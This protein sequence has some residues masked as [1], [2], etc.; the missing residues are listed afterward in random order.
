MTLPS[1]GSSSRISRYYDPP[2]T[3]GKELIGILADGNI[4]NL[5][6][7]FRFWIIWL[8]RLIG[9]VL[10]LVII[11]WGEANV[12]VIKSIP[13]RNLATYPRSPP[14]PP[15]SLSDIINSDSRI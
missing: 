1:I 5:T 14:S 8:Y 9:I 15:S 4:V 2:I 3:C 7:D 12:F 10:G 13:E 6:I 11:G